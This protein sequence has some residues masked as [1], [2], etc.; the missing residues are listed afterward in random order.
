MN[1]LRFYKKMNF[2]STFKANV[3]RSEYLDLIKNEKHRPAAV[4]K[5]RPSNYKLKIESDRYH[6][7]K[8]A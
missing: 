6:L 8:I 7:T 2:C 4:A 1:M 3:S 5:L